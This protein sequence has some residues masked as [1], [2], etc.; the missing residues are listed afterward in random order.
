M[1]T[2]INIF[3]TA[4]NNYSQ[5]LSVMITSILKNTHA[6]DNIVFHVFDFGIDSK[7][8]LAIEQLK[9]IKNFAIEYIKI[10]EEIFEK[11]QQYKSVSSHP[12]YISISTYVRLVI[13]DFYK[14]IKRCLWIDADVIVSESLNELFNYN[15]SDFTIGAVVD[16]WD[17][18]KPPFKNN[19]KLKE[20]SLYFN[21]GIL[22]INLENYNDTD[23]YTKLI[24]KMK[25]KEVILDLADQDILN[26]VFE[27][28]VF[29][30]PIKYNLQR[31]IFTSTYFVD[32][33]KYSK[34]EI[35][36]AK[37]SYKTQ[38]IVHYLNK[39]K[40]WSPIKEWPNKNVWSLYWY[41]IKFT[42]YKNVRFK[43]LIK[44]LLH[45][46]EIIWKN[47]K[48]SAIVKIIKTIIKIFNLFILIPKYTNLVYKIKK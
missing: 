2:N 32:R 37:K 16:I 27:D 3:T 38:G 31:P 10:T 15:I 45:H 19:L 26:L 46:F 28:D 44:S 39:D 24:S 13:F 18:W 20:E 48:K 6:D 36:L 33:E 14:D 1:S 9:K 5:H 22:L 17:W 29:I 30:L 34:L 35:K 25:D 11:L 40:P 41:Y 8:I 23:M 21:A 4:D 42:P 12:D 43:F 47:K 7:A